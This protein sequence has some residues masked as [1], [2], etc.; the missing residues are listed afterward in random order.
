MATDII[1]STSLKTTSERSAAMAALTYAE[2]E[3]IK[4][5]MREAV[6][7][8]QRSLDH[9]GPVVR[10]EC[11]F[12]GLKMSRTIIIHRQAHRIVWRCN[13]YLEL[14]NKSPLVNDQ[15]CGLTVSEAGE[16]DFG[17]GKELLI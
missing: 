4:K 15:W 2:I 3:D 8:A 11:P 13:G 1:K 9:D 14:E 7:T 16:I 10:P 5:R 6:V 17:F 12:C